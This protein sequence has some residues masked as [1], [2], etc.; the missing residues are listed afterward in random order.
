MSSSAEAQLAPSVTEPPR[1][2]VRHTMKAILHDSYGAFSELRV[3]EI[4]R[5]VPGDDQV[6]VRSRAAGLHVADC[7]GVLGAPLLMR[8]TTGWLKPKLGIPGFDVA[9]E[10]EAVGK[11]VEHFAPGD[12]VF[13]TCEGACAEFVCTSQDTLAHKPSNLSFEE[14]AA[15]PTSGLAALHALRDV[16]KLRPGQQVLI[17]GASGGVGTF[18]VQLAKAYGAVVTGVC[19]SKNVELLRS[20]GADH[21]ICY[22]QQDFTQVARRYDLVL[23][24]VENRSLSDCRSVLTPSGMLILNSGTG[25]SGCRFMVRLVKPLVLSP[26]VRHD[27]RRYLSMPSRDDLLQLKQL[28]ES[29]KL[30][31]VIAQ[32]YELHQTAEALRQIAAG[33]VP[34]KMVVKV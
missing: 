4:D 12:E 26:F 15:V 2:A 34:G 23:D 5:P 17:N 31:P 33:H 28:I 22:D 6:L 7:F 29:N 3:K 21:V 11:N 19:S 10:V 25:A 8:L 30:S 20:L 1:S 16:A 13:G 18:A 24:N 9:G 27:L 14:A 32:T